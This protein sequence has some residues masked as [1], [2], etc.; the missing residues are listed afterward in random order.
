LT[1]PTM[2]WLGL[3]FLIPTLVVFA[4]SFR[5]ATPYGGIGEGWTLD[6]IRELARPSYPILLWRTLWISGVATA[7]CL[8]GALPVAYALARQP[9]S[10]RRWLLLAVIIPF[11]TNFLIR[12]FAWKTLLHPD[13]YLKSLLVWMGW[14]EPPD[15]LLYNAGAVLIVIIY[16]YLPFAILPLYAA[17]EKFDFSL[18]EAATD[19]GASRLRA[20]WSIFLPG[21]SRGLLTAFLV[22]FIP[23]LG[24]YA[25]P[26]I[27]GGPD[28]NMIGNMIAQRTFVD[29]NLPHASALSASLALVVLLPL[30]LVFVMGD[31]EKRLQR[32]KRS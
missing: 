8:L 16:T 27:V 6:T 22:V 25:I 3:F 11:W 21:V 15:Q 5:P 30:V 14:V 26:N 13:G 32:R 10:R 2:F 17:A 20:F 18:L 7:V 31:R 23:A 9:Q 12:I 4:M 29:R 24:S 28:S 19:L 1:L